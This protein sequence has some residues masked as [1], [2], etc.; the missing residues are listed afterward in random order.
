MESACQLAVCKSSEGTSAIK[1]ATRALNQQ[2]LPK[3]RAEETGGTA[4]LIKQPSNPYP[5]P[6][7][8]TPKLIGA[9]PPSKNHHNSNT[10]LT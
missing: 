7:S 2:A 3:G 5:N 4:A 6:T 10:Y 9:S 1:P 8:K